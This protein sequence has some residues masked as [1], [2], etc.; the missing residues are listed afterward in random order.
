[1]ETPAMQFYQ[2]AKVQFESWLRDPACDLAPDAIRECVADCEREMQK[3]RER[4][5]ERARL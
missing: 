5:S 1:M 2:Q 3:L 4:D